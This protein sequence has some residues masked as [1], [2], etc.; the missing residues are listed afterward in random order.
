M[1][2]KEKE[3]SVLKDLQ[4][5]EKE[6][7]EK[8]ERYKQQAKD[9][10]LKQLFETLKQKEQQ[11]YDSLEQVINGTVPSVNCNDSD[12]ENYQPKATYSMTEESEDKK[13]DCFL[14]TDC[15]ASEKLVSGEYNTDVFVFGDSKV[16]KLLADIQIEEQNHAEM[17]YKY[18]TANAM[19]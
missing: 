19:A 7:I 6:C 18:K 3:I 13:S 10:E 2:L 8:Y 15:I 14:A 11:H 12:G 16:R 4:T 1:Q 17:L 5:Q 9:P